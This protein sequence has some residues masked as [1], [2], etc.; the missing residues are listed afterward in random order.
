MPQDYRLIGK[1]SA[2]DGTLPIML[3]D[4]RELPETSEN[5]WHAQ[6]AGW[7]RILTY[8][9][10]TSLS[11]ENYV[12]EGSAD[13]RKRIAQKR[14]DNLEDVDAGDMGRFRIPSS[15][16]VWRDEYP[17]ASTV[18]NAG[19]TWVGGA[20]A[21]EQRE[22]AKLISRFYSK[23]KARTYQKDHGRPF[24]FEV[25]VVNMPQDSKASG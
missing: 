2:N 11:D 6:M 7:P 23:Y 9:G 5:I 20:D 4:Y 8:D 17:F 14:R 12:F 19:S 1:P 16:A 22:Q 10:R 18:E 25:K 3:Y 21:E 13:R 24:W 15:M